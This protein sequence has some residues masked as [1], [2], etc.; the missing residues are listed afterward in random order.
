MRTDESCCRSEVIALLSFR[1]HVGNIV[2]LIAP[3]IHVN[4]GV[5]HAEGGMKHDPVLGYCLRKPQT[6]SKIV[7]IRILQSSRIAVLSSYED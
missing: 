3:G 5:E 4:R 1:E 2:A 7:R 6:W